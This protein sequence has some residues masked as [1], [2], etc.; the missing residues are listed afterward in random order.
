MAVVF[1]SSGFWPFIAAT[2]PTIKARHTPGRTN[3]RTT[4]GMKS[5]STN[6]GR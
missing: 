6:L 4:D 1:V 3:E 2:E 5:L